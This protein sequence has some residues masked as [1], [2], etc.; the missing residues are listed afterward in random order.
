[1]KP[2]C[3]ILLLSFLPLTPVLAQTD[4]TVT[5]QI[6]PVTAT[7][8]D[9][10]TGLTK[11]GAGLWNGVIRNSS[12]STIKIKW[13][14]L[15]LAFPQVNFLTGSEASSLLTRK[16][17]LGIWTII[18]NIFKDALTGAAVFFNPWFLVAQPITAQIDP[19]LAALQ[20]NV[21]ALL[22]QVTTTSFTLAPSDTATIVMLAGKMP[23]GAVHSYVHVMAAEPQP[24]VQPPAL[25]RELSAL[26]LR[27]EEMPRSHLPGASASIPS[28]DGAAWEP[29]GIEYVAFIPI[30]H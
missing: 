24:M 13:E 25:L 22:A 26:N 7:A 16:Q 5:L 15:Q 8:F 1:M 14:D 18:Y 19:Q 6:N 2:I 23:A 30:V 4:Q 9:Q 21:S 28:K 12:T 10:M 11:L 29:P 20:P 17:T 27:H 3:L